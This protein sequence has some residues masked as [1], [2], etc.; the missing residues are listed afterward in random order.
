MK[1]KNPP[2]VREYQYLLTSLKMELNF[3]KYQDP[4][5]HDFVIKVQA[6]QTES[7]VQLSIS[8]ETKLLKQKRQ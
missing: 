4:T 1:K 5:L 3:Y 6:M 8:F 7:A 2:K